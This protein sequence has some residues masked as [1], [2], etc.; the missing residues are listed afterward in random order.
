M[1]W[2]KVIVSSASNRKGCENEQQTEDTHPYSGVVSAEEE[3]R[4][5]R[6]RSANAGRRGKKTSSEQLRWRFPKNWYAPYPV[7]G[8]DE[9]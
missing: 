5:H 2:D 6:W 8:R 3:E 7:Q 4:D 1:I 9:T